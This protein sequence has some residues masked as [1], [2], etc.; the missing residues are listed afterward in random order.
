MTDA[1][2]SRIYFDSNVFIYA[3]EGGIDI[4]RAI[5]RLLGVLMR[6]STPAVTSEFT[7]AEV[8]AR[9][10]SIRRRYYLN[11]IAW[12]GAVELQPVSRSILI[13]TASFRQSAGMPKLADAVH[14]VTAVRSGCTRVLTGDQRMKVPSG[15]AIVEADIEG[16]SKL[17]GEL[18]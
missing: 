15:L 5:H 2:S 17:A 9:A 18:A 12:S 7:L 3:G 13:E 14:V 4:A 10:D 11:L 8:L 16:I 6:R 1:G